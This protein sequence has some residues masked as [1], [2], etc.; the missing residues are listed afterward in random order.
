MN[1]TLNLV[2]CDIRY[3]RHY[4]GLWLGLV[5]LQAFLIGSYGQLP[6]LF[7]LPGSMVLEVLVPLMTWLVAILKI[8][9]LAVIIAQLVHKDSTIGSTAFWLSRP[10]SRARLL[11]G[12]ALFLAVAVILPSLLVE[13]GLLFLS[14]V[15]PHNTLRSVPQILFLTLLAVAPLMMLASV[16]RNL[17]RMSLLGTLVFLGLP[18]LGFLLLF[19]LPMGLWGLPTGIWILGMNAGP[20]GAPL[21][22]LATAVIVIG[23]QYLTRR[24]VVSRTLLFSGVCLAILFLGSWSLDWPKTGEETPV[25]P[26]IL[27]PAKIGPSIDQSSLSL[28]RAQYQAHR[29]GPSSWGTEEK[30]VLL[31]GSIEMGSLPPGTMAF[32]H[33]IHARLRLPSGDTLARHSGTHRPRW[34]GLS[35]IHQKRDIGQ[36]EPAWLTRLPEDVVLLFALKESQ[37]ER[38]RGV[39]LV[40]SAEVEFI[41]QRAEAAELRPVKGVRLDQSSDHTEILSVGRAGSDALT[42]QLCETSHR[43]RGEDKTEARY[44]LV[45]PSRGE[46]LPASIGDISLSSPPLLSGIVP[47]LEVRRTR[48]DFHRPP[49]GVE[50]DAAWLEEAELVRLETS[51]LGSFYKSIRM[52]ALVLDQLGPPSATPPFGMDD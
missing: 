8:C 19:L 21:V 17:A 44:F 47:M 31:R 51:N 42:I 32:P 7:P 49:D 13:V 25:D 12:K 36:G 27:D 4:L 24:A 43:L 14:G 23:Y 5:I 45:N 48:L 15:T 46:A 1:L 26:E 29:W 11:A 38:Y 35:S 40:Y 10:V 18:L 37:Y 39:P 2:A 9:L 16:T 22:L 33:T 50:M 30:R 41:V 6:G 28:A 34:A 20:L 3:L 52:E